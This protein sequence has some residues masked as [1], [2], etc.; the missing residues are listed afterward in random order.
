M[1]SYRADIDGLRAWSILLVVIF[2]AFPDVLQGGFIGVDVFFVISG[3]LITKIILKG[4]EENNF[5]YFRFFDKRIRR[6]Y[7]SLL[8]VLIFTFL[9]SFFLFNPLDFGKLGKYIFSG[10]F[11]ISNL[12]LWSEISYFNDLTKDMPLLHLWSLGVEEQFYIFLPLILGLTRIWNVSPKKLI[13]ILF[14][15]SLTINLITYKKFPEMNFYSPFTRFWEILLGSILAIHTAKPE[16]NL[17]NNLLTFFSL[18]AIIASGFILNKNLNYPGYFSLIPVISTGIII[19][20]GEKTYITKI[21]LSNI[22]TRNLGKISYPLYLW[23]W[24]ILTFI[25]TSKYKDN[26]S[27]IFSGLFLSLSLSIITYFFIEQKIR[28]NKQKYTSIFLFLILSFIGLLGLSINKKDIDIDNKNMEQVLNY[29]YDYSVDYR[30]GSCFLKPEQSYSDFRNCPDTIEKDKPNIM[31]WGDSHAAHLYPGFKEKFHN[32]A[33][34]FQRTASGCPPLLNFHNAE[35]PECHAINNEIKLLLEKNNFDI[36]YLAAAWNHYDLKNLDETLDFIYNLNA[37]KVYLVG[38]VPQW[39]R[40]LPIKIYDYLNK[41][42]TNTIPLRITEDDSDKLDALDTFL[43]DTSRNYNFHY[44]SPR[45][46]LCNPEGCL[47]KMQD[48]PLIF[49]A[50]DYGHLTKPAAIYLVNEF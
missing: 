29:K 16:E 46:I 23:H 43:A 22:F 21:F 50:W 18:A 28:F 1:S 10:S 20:Y 41:N 27:V 17:K 47:A 11:F 49:S 8:A 13:Y 34:I 4:F 24:P 25:A 31:I 30:E 5:S 42:K 14:F 6:L 44:I 37:S 19:F 39:N 3:F 45:K 35:R 26:I 9:T 33:N 48:N 36:I 12:V 2:H 15:L 40:N 7:P 38:P 32:I